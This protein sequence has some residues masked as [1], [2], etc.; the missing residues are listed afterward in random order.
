MLWMYQ[1][2]FHGEPSEAVQSHL[3]DLRPREWLAI[4]PLLALMLWMGTFTRTFLPPISATNAVILE[5]TKMN[6]QFLVR[7][8]PPAVRNEPP[9][10]PREVAD[11]R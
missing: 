1:R 6:A 4:V 9:A 2:A 11:V 10:S 7:S 3:W 8:D 5:Q